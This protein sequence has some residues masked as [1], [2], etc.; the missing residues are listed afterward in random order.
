MHFSEKTAEGIVTE[1]KT[2]GHRMYT[3]QFREHTHETRY[4]NVDRC[5]GFVQHE[6]LPVMAHRFHEARVI[7]GAL[8]Y[9]KGV[10]AITSPAAA[11]AAAGQLCYFIF[12]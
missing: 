11:A 6:L 1:K 5:A 12:Y 2:N 8:A 7:D 3:K 4:G 9:R 10:A